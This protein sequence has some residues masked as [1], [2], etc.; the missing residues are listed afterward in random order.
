MKFAKQFK[1]KMKERGITQAQLAQITGLNKHE[2]ACVLSDLDHT[3]NTSIQLVADS[4]W[5]EIIVK[6]K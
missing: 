6:D 3:S 1:A 5:L 2:I 4:L